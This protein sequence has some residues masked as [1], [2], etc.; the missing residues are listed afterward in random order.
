[1]GMPRSTYTSLYR[2]GTLL[3]RHPLVARVANRLIQQTMARREERRNNL[4]RKIPDIV[5]DDLKK[6]A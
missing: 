6:A 5:E 4:I 1:M 3:E 2:F